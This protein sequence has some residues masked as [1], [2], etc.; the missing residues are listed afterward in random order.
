MTFPEAIKAG[1]RNYAEFSGKATR[2]EFWWWILFTIIVSSVLGAIPI[3]TFQYPDGTMLFAP[4]LSPAWHLAVLLPTLA[5]GVRR[6]RH[7]GHR[8]GH[9]FWVLLPVAGMIILAVLC[10]QPPERQVIAWSPDPR[11]GG[12]P[13]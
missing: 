4:T 11:A 12:V 7:A 8:W 9:V 5:V 3:P 10:V 6:L 13:S 1:F 2:S